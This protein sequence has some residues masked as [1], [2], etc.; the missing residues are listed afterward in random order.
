M[1]CI[2]CGKNLLAF[3]SN[4]GTG[5]S[6]TCHECAFGQAKQAGLLAYV[7]KSIVKSLLVAALILLVLLAL[8]WFANP[9][10]GHY[11]SSIMFFS[12]LMPRLAVIVLLIALS[13]GLLTGFIKWWIDKKRN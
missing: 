3:R 2:R 12:F 6:P 13:I 9:Y 4:Y 11:A 8:V 10:G 5:E 7:L 1:K